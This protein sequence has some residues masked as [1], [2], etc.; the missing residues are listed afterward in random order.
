MRS[1]ISALTTT[2]LSESTWPDFVELF[3]PKS[4]WNHCWCIHFQRPCPLPKSKWLRSRA[5]R[6]IRNRREK[7]ILVDQGYAHGILVYANRQPVGWCQYGPKDELPRI[8]NSRNYLGLST[9]SAAKKVWRI[10]CFVVDKKFRARGVATAALQA[11]LE[12]IKKKGG[13]LVEAY[14]V[15]DWPDLKVSELRRRDRI[16]SFGNISTHGT[17]SMFKKQGFKPV[18]PFGPTNVLMRKMI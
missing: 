5:K 6:S 18:A 9:E 14:P 1:P 3:A 4:G 13:G 2:E 7:K 16:P 10:T 8:D 12:S 11:A 17:V 15:L